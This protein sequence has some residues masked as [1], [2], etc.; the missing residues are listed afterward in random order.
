M[1]R[2]EA[3]KAF[4]QHKEADNHLTHRTSVVSIDDRVVC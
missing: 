4:D 2:H 3:A 1:Q